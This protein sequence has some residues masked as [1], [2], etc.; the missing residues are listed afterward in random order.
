MKKRIVVAVLIPLI[1]V[2][3]CVVNS[4]KKPPKAKAGVLNL[5]DWDFVKDG[6][7]VLRGEWEIY[8][9]QLLQSKRVTDNPSGYMS[10]PSYWSSFQTA[11][12]FEKSKNY[13]SHRLL[14]YLPKN[15]KMLTAY[16]P[17]QTSSYALYW[18]GKQIAKSGVVGDSPAT[19]VPYFSINYKHIEVNSQNE[20]VMQIANFVENRAGFTGSIR[21]GLAEQIEHEAGLK[22]AMELV[23]FGAISIIGLYH[24]IL[25]LFRAREKAVLYFGVFCILIS[26]R[27]VTMADYSL[28]QLLPNLP[29]S[30]TRRVEYFS[31]YLAVP[32]FALFAY[33]IFRQ[34]FPKWLLY[35]VLVIGIPCSAL[36]LILPL[37]QFSATLLF[38]EVF[39]LAAGLAI[40][41]FV[42]VRSLLH[43]HADALPFLLGWLLLFA[44]VVH[45]I[46]KNNLLLNS[47]WL[48]SAGLCFFIFAQSVILARRFTKAR[49]MIENLTGELKVK[50]VEL[51]QLN[52][53]K[54]EFLANISHEMRTPL[55]SVAMGV[56]FL[57][58]ATATGDLK[59]IAL[60]NIRN[61]TVKLDRLIDRMLLS[62]DLGTGS[63]DYS[64][65]MVDVA[66]VVKNVFS[67]I[68]PKFPSLECTL[69]TESFTVDA[70]KNL[71][72]TLFNELLTNVAL[73]G[74]GKCT[75]N[76]QKAADYVE[77]S[78]AD[79]GPGVPP[80]IITKLGQKFQR[81]DVSTTYETP[82]MG[83][84]LYLCKKIIDIFKGSIVFENNTPRGFLVTLNIPIAKKGAFSEKNSSG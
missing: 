23:M 54:D 35:G 43:K 42:P 41:I 20:I 37:P 78:I 32:I 38:Y 16:F 64:F 11:E 50:N 39:T 60:E 17:E 19:T 73:Y 36:T 81:L 14:L 71:T 74:K 57:E 18:N 7:V 65:E 31:Y 33:N 15:T 40:G 49:Q 2:L 68:T 12:T 10:V 44:A 83:L 22:R 79:S 67:E 26:L 51:I 24:L 25:F 13:A 72:T 48:T 63:K 56:D 58:D 70:N 47:P 3:S 21:L 55:T 84:G 29:H 27:I 69:S 9:H 46:V 8:W 53:M 45:D 76:M 82:G 61:G 66:L 77:I 80:E 75:I 6:P 30:L 59:T 28:L 1:F 34:T 52:S 5:T 4:A 62:S